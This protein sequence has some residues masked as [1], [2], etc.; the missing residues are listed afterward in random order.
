MPRI[1]VSSLEDPRVRDYRDVRDRELVN[2]RG[3]FIV[4]SPL[5]VLRFAGGARFPLRSVFVSERLGR[6]VEQLEALLP[7][8]RPIYTA[9]PSLMS[10]VVGFPIHRG[11]LAVGERGDEPSLEVLLGAAEPGLVVVTEALANADNVGSVFRNAAAFG[12]R[13]VV[14]DAESCDPLYRRA[15]RVSVGA[16]L[17]LPF[18]RVSRA[19]EALEILRARGYL[20]VGLTP[21]PAAPTLAAVAAELRAESKLALFLG[22]EGAGLG[23]G[24]LGRVHTRAC[25]PMAAGMDSINVAAATAVALYALREGRASGRPASEWCPSNN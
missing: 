15:I 17:S 3:I 13:M 20:T 1:P 10:E 16:A 24:V 12:A 14:V 21:D 25:I 6:L 2:E 18:A 5:S 9:P 4:E 8:D 7:S 11:C 22:T 19:T 23:E